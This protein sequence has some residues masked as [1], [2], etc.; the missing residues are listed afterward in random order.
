[1]AT[2][3][4]LIRLYRSARDGFADD[5]ELAREVARAWLDAQAYRLYTFGSVTRMMDGGEL[6]ADSSLNKL[7][8]SEMDVATHEAAL[9]LL[10]PGAELV[11]GTD[12][13]WRL[14][15]DYRRD[16][17]FMRTDPVSDGVLAFERSPPAK[18]VSDSTAAPET[19]S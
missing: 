12:A 8:W 9:D 3:S 18:T 2:A 5:P 10:G 4:R 6:G 14:N 13:R 11:G 7:F 1:M 16:R 19:V 17:V 15:Q